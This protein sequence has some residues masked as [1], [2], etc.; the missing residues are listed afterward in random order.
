MTKGYCKPY[1]QEMTEAAC[2]SKVQYARRSKTTAANKCLECDGLDLKASIPKDV[3]PE[4]VTPETPPK[5]KGIVCQD[6]GT[7][8]EETHKF[9]P[10]DML[11]RACYMVKYRKDVKTGERVQGD[12]LS[13]E[14]TISVDFRKFPELFKEILDLSVKEF[15]SPGMQILYMIKDK[16]EVKDES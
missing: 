8:K 10:G 4:T 2:D 7:P 16:L 15:R 11:C 6:C 1:N 3:T 9:Y 14:H 12:S 13:N 5:K